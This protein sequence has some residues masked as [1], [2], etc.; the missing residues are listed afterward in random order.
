MFGEELVYQGV[1]QDGS[2]CSFKASVEEI[3]RWQESFRTYYAS[4]IYVGQ[5]GK[6]LV[7]RSLQ[8]KS[9]AGEEAWK[10]KFAIRRGGKD[11]FFA[12]W[13][14]LDRPK[15]HSMKYYM[16]HLYHIF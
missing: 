1:G 11:D 14:M 13:M 16:Y 9:E 6:E 10:M 4:D 15:D 7:S 12:V 5:E 2:P 3:C 8:G